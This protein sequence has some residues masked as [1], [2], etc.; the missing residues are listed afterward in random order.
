[1]SAVPQKDNVL[2]FSKK[3]AAPKISWAP[4]V[5]IAPRNLSRM[6][7]ARENLPRPDVQALDVRGRLRNYQRFAHRDDCPTLVVFESWKRREASRRATV[8]LLES[9]HSGERWTS[10]DTRRPHISTHLRTSPVHRRSGGRR[11][12]LFR[13]D[14]QRASYSKVTRVISWNTGGE[15][16]IHF[17]PPTFDITSFYLSLFTCTY[18]VLSWWLVVWLVGSATTEKK[19]RFSEEKENAASGQISGA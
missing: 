17:W 9:F 10:P 8:K 12:R 5:H 2:H 16:M 19:R 6:F 3:E 7:S 13:P 11:P 14:F 18:K 1:M 4:R 15:R